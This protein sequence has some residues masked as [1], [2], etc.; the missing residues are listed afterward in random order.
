VPVSR[1]GVLKDNTVNLILQSSRPPNGSGAAN[2]RVRRIDEEDLAQVADLLTR[3]F[4]NRPRR[5]WLK[6]LACLRDRP[7][8]AGLPK[9]GYLLEKD[10]IVGVILQ[11]FAKFRSDE[12]ATI[13][14]NVSSWYVEPGFRI[15]ANLLV[16]RALS[17]ENVTYLNV[18]PSPTTFPILKAQGYSQYSK[19]V[20]VAVP[21][22]QP[23]GRGARVRIAKAE[24]HRPANVS[25]FEHDLLIDH[26]KFGC[27]SLW[28][29]TAERA[30]AFVFRPKVAKRVIPSL[31][32]VYCQELDSFVKFA[33]PLGR[34]LALQ[35]RAL[36][37]IDSNGPIPG[38]IGTYVEAKMPR[39][40][41]G[42]NRP[43]LGDLAYTEIAMFGL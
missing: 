33:A 2:I 34:F 4:Q 24:A 17:H 1:A 26:A 19:G 12:T 15:Y 5:F 7:T 32:L 30:Y 35:G 21:A 14:C 28:C 37:L 8:V 42:E 18:T 6:I 27:I 16:A 11:I 38:L 43:R 9:Y 23:R 3:G 13:R 40:F 10:R 20:F 25:Q 22:L 36:V 39:F 29:E 41:K 31:Q